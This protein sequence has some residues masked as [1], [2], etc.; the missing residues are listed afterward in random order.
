[1]LAGKRLLI[2]CSGKKDK[3][4]AC[5]ICRELRDFRMVE[6][7]KEDCMDRTNFILRRAMPF[8]KRT[9]T[10]EW[11]EATRLDEYENSSTLEDDSPRP[12]KD[13][14]R[15]S[16]AP[17]KSSKIS[18]TK[19]REN[20][21][22]TKIER[23]ANNKVVI[24]F[25]EQFS[26]VDR[27]PQT[28]DDREFMAKEKKKFYGI[29]DSCT[30][31]RGLEQV[32]EN[33]D[34]PQDNVLNNKNNSVLIPGPLSSCHGETSRDQT[35][36]SSCWSL[37][38]ISDDTNHFPDDDLSIISKEDPSSFLHDTN[39]F[40]DPN[41]RSLSPNQLET[42]SFTHENQRE[43]IVKVTPSRQDVLKIEE[44][45]TVLADYWSLPGD[46]TGFRADWSFVQQWRLRG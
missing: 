38:R 29:P 26:A 25:G 21:T 10:K 27:S 46:T 41:N 40:D 36:D 16:V 43:I 5:N 3:N 13:F 7:N 18:E 11:Q 33:R 4:C 31:Q 28:R 23:D 45:D 22:E 20:W 6:E 12:R 9:P 14:S 37:N 8:V 19:S 15:G 32:Q 39:D 42:Q 34:Q 44:D 30:G 1:M 17:E 2:R 24:Y 35:L